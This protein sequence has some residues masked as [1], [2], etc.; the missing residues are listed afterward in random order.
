M[1]GEVIICSEVI[2]N[3][4]ASLPQA[5]PPWSPTSRL[6][7]FSVKP[8]AGFPPLIHSL[9]QSRNSNTAL[10][11]GDRKAGSWGA[12]AWDPFFFS[13]SDCVFRPKPRIAHQSQKLITRPQ[14][15]VLLER[16]LTLGPWV[17]AYLEAAREM[18]PL[19]CEAPLAALD[20]RISALICR[21]QR[22]REPALLQLSRRRLRR[23]GFCRDQMLQPQGLALLALAHDYSHVCQ[24]SSP[25]LA[26]LG[27]WLA[28]DNTFKHAVAI[29]W[30][31]KL[32]LVGVQ[33]IEI[34]A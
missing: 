8:E 6:F 5:L 12:S 33:L 21:L 20:P 31:Y 4:I 13:R 9:A 2:L 19:S 17:P 16:D 34:K 11:N 30:P 27:S 10:G 14:R 24:T 26:I 25:A 23:P 3:F 1:L 32:I 22:R 18:S 7:S 28:A 15:S 29:Y